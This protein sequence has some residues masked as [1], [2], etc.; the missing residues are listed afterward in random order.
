MHA[1]LKKCL[2]WSLAALL[3]LPLF[4]VN[5]LMYMSGN[6]LMAIGMLALLV[7]GIFIYANSKGYVYRY[8]FPGLLG[9]FIFV[10]FP[11]VYTFWISFHKYDAKNLLTRERVEGILRS[12]TYEPEGATAFSYQIFRTEKESD[13]QIVLKAKN[14]PPPPAPAG[15]TAEASAEE[16]SESTAEAAP[17]PPEEKSFIS[18]VFT[19]PAFEKNKVLVL[20]SENDM[21]EGDPLAIGDITRGKLHIL[22]RDIKLQLPDE[23]IVG[24]SSLREFSTQKPVWSLKDDGSLENNQDGRIVRPNPETG[25]F[26][27]EAGEKVGVGF[28]TWTGA[29][30][31]SR[32]VTDERIKK[33]FARIFVW[34]FTFAFLSMATTFALGMFLAVLLEWEG[35]KGRKFYR[36]LLIFP[37]A[38]PAFLSILTFQGMFNQEFGAVNEFLGALFNISPEWN[39][40][41]WLARLM[42]LIVNLW[43]G[44]PYMMIICTGNLQSISKNIYE[45]SAIDGSNPWANFRRL[46]LPLVLPPMVPVLIASFAFNFNNFN[47][48]YLLT[49]GRPRMVGGS[50]IAGETDIL[51]TYTFNLAFKNSGADYGLASAIATILFVIVGILAWLNLKKTQGS[52]S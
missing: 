44:Y 35:L 48:I 42:I 32:I 10:I 37:Y 33:P 36:T 25:F 50:G 51:V 12:E 26:E 16:D 40:N 17:A 5:F 3:L 34:T 18:P 21:P 39:S 27:T 6:L 30:N 22:L 45:A 29:E 11:L 38:V 19:L 8:L 9:F 14:P 20:N 47:L 1:P 46:T 13:Y 43:L 2:K 52:A 23:Q 28:R 49:A 15:Q 31:Y 24:L 41:P 4:Y 7:I